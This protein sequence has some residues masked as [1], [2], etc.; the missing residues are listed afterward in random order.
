[1]TFV[2]CTSS[3]QNK[4]IK[5]CFTG[6]L[7]ISIY[8]L[9]Y[10]IKY[11]SK[12]VKWLSFNEKFICVFCEVNYSLKLMNNFQPSVFIYSIKE[13][14]VLQ[15]SVHKN[16]NEILLKVALSTITP[17]PPPFQIQQV[18]LHFKGEILNKAHDAAIVL[19]SSLLLN[20]SLI[21]KF[22]HWNF[23]SQIILTNL[24]EIVLTDR[25]NT[26][27][28]ICLVFGWSMMLNATFNNISVISWRSVLLVEETGVPVENYWPVASN[29]QTLQ[30][31]VVWST[32]RHERGSN[33]H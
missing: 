19:T 30:K 32:S 15:N 27:F 14:T 5:I 17:L 26:L 29:W 16:I 6:K 22:S 4:N 25:S 3:L 23:V 31:N 9:D 21:V 2:P 12:T 33:S 18:A 20:N 7:N 28:F 24:A 1:M 10:I 11:N 8:V 13:F